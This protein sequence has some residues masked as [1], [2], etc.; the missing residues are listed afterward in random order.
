MAEFSV[1]GLEFV[2]LSSA[3]L[4]V[5][6]SLPQT[7]SADFAE[8]L[9]SRL[10]GLGGSSKSGKDEQQAETRVR[11][12]VTGRWIRFQGPTYTKLIRQGILVEGEEEFDHAKVALAAP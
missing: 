2:V 5:L 7:D 12:P 3:V 8:G 9:S 6:A 1:Q 10:L 11:N 4:A